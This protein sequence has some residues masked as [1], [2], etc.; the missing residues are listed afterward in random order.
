[1]RVLVCGDRNWSDMAVIRREMEKLPQGTVIIHGDCIGADRIAGHYA[2]AWGWRM[3]EY[4]AD[5]LTYGRAAGPI[6]NRQMLTEGKPDLVLAFHRD[7]SQSRGTKDMV[8]AA[9]KA[10]VEVRV[11]DG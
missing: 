7:L 4:P 6:R 1:M 8:N 9:R 5:W 11:V 3:Q 2:S 10:G